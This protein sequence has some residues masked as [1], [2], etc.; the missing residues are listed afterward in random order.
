MRSR[1]CLTVLLLG[2]S[3]FSAHAES[4]ST[5]VG[6]ASQSVDRPVPDL[7]DCARPLST[8]NGSA[9]V[10]YNL[11]EHPKSIR[12]QA[13][14][15]L[16]EAVKGDVTGEQILFT[17]TPFKDLPM[18]RQPQMC[19]S[20]AEQTRATPLTYGP[21]HF[22]EERLL[23]DWISEFTQGQ[24]VEGKKL[25]AECGGDCDP[26]YTFITPGQQGLDLR[27]EVFCGLIRD[28][29]GEDM[30]RLETALRT[31]CVTPVSSLHR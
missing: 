9:A 16:A 3:A 28:R 5:A 6:R 22:S 18:A 13:R 29:A 26:T 27:A 20:L 19:L 12:V 17:V 21:K 30:F 23:D 10:M 2:A 11:A 31:P 15:M 4:N 14:K 25:Y 24:G 8:Q 1:S 7:G